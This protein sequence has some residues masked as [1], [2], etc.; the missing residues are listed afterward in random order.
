[1]VVH[2]RKKGK[3][4]IDTLKKVVSGAKKAHEVAKAVSAITGVK[5]SAHVKNSLLS[6]AL[7]S[8]GLGRKRVH[9]KRGGCMG[10][11]RPHGAKGALGNMGLHMAEVRAHKKNGGRRVK[12]GHHVGGLQTQSGVNNYP[13]SASLGVVKF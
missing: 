13:N 12:M 5:P 4:I 7:K 6:G 10:D 11:G 1:M 2:R 8:A 9:R 3:G